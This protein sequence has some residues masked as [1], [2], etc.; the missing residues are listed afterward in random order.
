[1][2]HIILI[3]LILIV[4]LEAIYEGLYDKGNKSLSKHIQCIWIA[5]FFGLWYL[6][7]FK[8]IYFLIYLNIRLLSFDYIYKK[9]SGGKLCGTTSGWYKYICPVVHLAPVIWLLVF[10]LVILLINYYELINL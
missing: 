7:I 9:I 4:V 6:T 1:V 5:C 3:L 10:T 8:W 2:K